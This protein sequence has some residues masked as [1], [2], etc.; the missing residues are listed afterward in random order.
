[1]SDNG[2]T[3][4]EEL[5]KALEHL[6]EDANTH[7]V[8]GETQ[9]LEGHAVI[10]VASIGYGG[11][12][13]FGGSREPTSEESVQVGEGMGG[14]FGVSAKPLGAIDVTADGVSWSPLIN[15]NRLATIWSLFVGT[16]LL[17]IVGG[18]LGR[19]QGAR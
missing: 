14:G 12:G 6:G 8:F 7:M 15:W 16:A 4:T 17:M 11:G 5:V 18:V 19:R 10:P 13:G 3:S 1:M 2:K 9:V